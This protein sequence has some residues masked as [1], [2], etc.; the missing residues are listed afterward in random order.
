[1][2]F[3]QLGQTIATIMMFYG[4]FEGRSHE[5]RSD[6]KSGIK[7]DSSIE[8]LNCHSHSLTPNN[9]LAC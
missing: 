7:L 5:K 8:I 4:F 9:L 1:M 2:A 3:P 6:I